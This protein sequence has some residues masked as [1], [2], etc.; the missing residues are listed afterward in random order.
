[1]KKTN[2]RSLK[3]LTTADFETF[4]ADSL[5]FKNHTVYKKDGSVYYSQS[6]TNIYAYS[7]TR[8]PVRYNKM[9]K[10]YE[11][12]QRKKGRSLL[13]A[14]FGWTINNFMKDI[15]LKDH[16]HGQYYKEIICWFHNGHKF[17]LHFIHAWLQEQDNWYFYQWD[18]IHDDMEVDKKLKEFKGKNLYHYEKM[19]KYVVLDVYIW[20]EEAQ[21]HIHVDFWDSL[22][23]WKQSVA[24]ISETYLL[25]EKQSDIKDWILANFK[26]ELGNLRKVKEI[27]FNDYQNIDDK[28]IYLS[29]GIKV[30]LT[31]NP[32]RSHN[33]IRTLYD[34]VVNDSDIMA[35][36]FAYLITHNVITVPTQ[37]KLFRTSGSLAIGRFAHDYIE[38]HKIKRYDKGSDVDNYKPEVFWQK[39]IWEVSAEEKEEICKFFQ[40]WLTGGFVSYNEQYLRKIVKDKVIFSYDVNSL[41]PWVVSTYELPYGSMITSDK[42]INDMYCFVY[43]ECDEIQQLMLR[44][45]NMIPKKWIKDNEVITVKDEQ[46]IIR[47]KNGNLNPVYSKLPQYF[48]HLKGNIKCFLDQP[49]YE[50]IYM[51]NNW[52]K[53]YGIKNIKW[54]CFK[55]K[56]FMKDYMDKYYGAKMNAKSTA[57]KEA[58]K[59]NMNSPT[60]KFGEKIF[61]S[62]QFCVGDIIDEDMDFNQL[63]DLL[64][65][66]VLDTAKDEVLK[67][68]KDPIKYSKANITYKTVKV[69][70]H[71]F[72]PAYQAITFRARYKTMFTALSMATKYKD[73]WVLYCDTDSI[74]G[75]SD[76]SLFSDAIVDDKKLGYW[77]QEFIKKDNKV[78]KFLVMRAKYWLC[79]WDNGKLDGA[80]GGVNTKDVL[81]ALKDNIENALIVDKF[82]TKVSHLTMYGVV[83]TDE[84]KAMSE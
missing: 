66:G 39:Y 44:V 31:T 68:L 67:Y 50:D 59:I 84:Y 80:T 14:K 40:P 10:A 60:G 26:D 74:K 46:Y 37:S 15:Q 76:G 69:A 21:Y 3:V 19:T 62:N 41:Y 48:T 22:M 64:D 57:E 72:Y 55:T 61:K 25:N 5:Y 27:D 53:F 56:Y 17:D 52:F 43:F 29:D 54:Y 16:R 23:L 24:G 32:K 83:I 12:L 51:N 77:K 9:T 63:E 28:Y 7:L 42:P 71:A 4:T 47:N 11:L 79:Q 35:A 81:K 38:Q 1:M 8:I 20:N 6:K 49:L 34:R 36:F 30:E 65:D 33:K 70:N 82:M 2:S 18:D 45:P 13:N 75:F 58:A 78:V 73:L